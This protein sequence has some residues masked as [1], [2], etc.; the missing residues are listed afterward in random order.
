MSCAGNTRLFACTGIL[1]EHTSV[2]TSASLV[3]SSDD[4]NKIDNDLRVS[5]ANY[6]SVF[7]LVQ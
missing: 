6:S 5:I 7:M 2:L 3:R 4:E 1:I